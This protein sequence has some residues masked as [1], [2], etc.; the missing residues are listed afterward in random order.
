M[1]YDES[2]SIS[3]L[4]LSICKEIIESLNGTIKAENNKMGGL[5][6]IFKIDSYKE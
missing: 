2:R 4:G 5:S 6:I 1:G 3:G